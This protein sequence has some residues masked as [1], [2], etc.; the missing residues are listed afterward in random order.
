ML[1]M[2]GQQ[3]WP[4]H[5]ERWRECDAQFVGSKSRCA[6]YEQIP[7]SGTF[8]KDAIEKQAR[9]ELRGRQPRLVDDAE[10][11]RSCGGILQLDGGG[12]EVL[13]QHQRQIGVR[14]RGKRCVLRK[15]CVQSLLRDFARPIG[16]VQRQVKRRQVVQELKVDLPGRQSECAFVCLRRGFQIVRAVLACPDGI[17]AGRPA[18]FEGRYAFKMHCGIGV[19]PEFVEGSPKLV[20]VVR[21]VRITASR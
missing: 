16:T 4:Q 15:E 19:F 6:V 20:V 8:R 1:K 17:P 3:I 11:C 5:T 10:L 12:E 2:C 21:E 14:C 9:E 18:V 13:V 7:R